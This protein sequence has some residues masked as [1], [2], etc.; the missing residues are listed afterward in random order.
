VHV[1]QA[2]PQAGQQEE[3]MTVKVQVSQVIDRPLAE[4]FQ[5]YAHDHVRNH[6]RWDPEMELE[7]ITPGPIGVGTVIRRRN[8]HSG[9]P[10]EGTMEVVEFEPDRAMAVIIHDGPV[11]THGWITS[12]ATGPN[13]TTITIIAEFPGMDD[14]MDTTLLTTMIGR[15]TKNMKH[16][17]ESEANNR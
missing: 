12:E 6:P 10:V 1:D 5:F 16:I 3:S 14:S 7:Q 13:Q 11:E 2:E 4:V 17:I 15:S 9:T 8:S